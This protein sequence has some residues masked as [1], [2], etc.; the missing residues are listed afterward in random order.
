[1]AT[2][3]SARAS[4]STSG[5]TCRPRR[6]APVTPRRSIPA[7]GGWTAATSCTSGSRTTARQTV[8]PI[9]PPAPNTPTR[10]V[11]GRDSHE[12]A[13]T[14]QAP[15]PAGP[16]RT[17]RTRRPGTPCSRRGSRRRA[18][19]PPATPRRAR[20]PAGG[21][22]RPRPA[23]GPGARV[24]PGAAAPAGPQVEGQRTPGVE[25][26]DPGGAGDAVPLGPPPRPQQVVDRRPRRLPPSL[27]EPAAFGVGLEAQY[28]DQLVRLH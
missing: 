12:R 22:R 27:G 7:C 16:A 28:R 14:G 19:P 17:G 21:G 13:T 1:M 18:A 9:R 11:T 3:A 6:S 10:I 2:R 20:P 4:D 5:D 23:P 26:P 24:G 15:S 25:V 8:D